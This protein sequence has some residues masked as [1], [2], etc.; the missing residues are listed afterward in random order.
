MALGPPETQATFEIADVHVSPKTLHPTK[1]TS[2][3][4]G[5][6]ELEMATMT[7]LIATAWGIE[8]HKVLG[9]PDW[10][11]MERFDVIARAPSG[12]TQQALRPMLQ[13]LLEKRFGLA[14]HMD[15]RP[16]VAAYVLSVGSGKPK[17]KESDSAAPGCQR[18]AQPPE[19]GP[20]PAVC[21]GLTMAAFAAQLGGAA[22]DYLN[23]PVVDN[24]KLEGAWDF[25]LKWTPRGRLAAAGAE[26]ITIFDAIDKQLGLKLE[27]K[28]IPAP[29][30]VVD[31]VNRKPTDNP[32][33]VAASLPPAPPPHFEVA[34]LRPTDPQL[35]APVFQ[36]PPNGQ[37]TIRGVTLSYLVQ[38]VWFVTP[39]MIADAPKWMDTDR[40]DIVAKVSSTPG[41]AP[42]TDMD[43]MIVMVRQLLED[44]FRLKTHMEERAVRAYTLT[45]IK[46]KLQRADPANRTGCK[47][48][49]GA[50]RKDPRLTNPARA[51]L[52]TCRNM[53]MAQFADR[54]PNIANAM[55]QLN[56][57]IRSPVA[58]STGLSGAWG[59]TLSFT[60]GT[61][62]QPAASAPA[63]SAEPAEPNGA[64]SLEEA[65]SSQLGL[66]LELMKRPAQLLVIDHVEQQPTEN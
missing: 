39:E 21:H 64:L 14:V 2:F 46:P 58:D 19:A 6:F 40:W 7:D 55:N 66:K 12:T 57:N 48:G 13:S 24:T 42:R 63:V 4:D 10:L 20:I 18:Q 9:G 43:S 61:G 36:T 15:Q 16:F 56:T 44:R 35:Q 34:T 37:I 49:P 54:L 45:A 62:A 29:V 1:R 23:A 32:P 33:G 8:P 27:A 50:D 51:R 31:R 38:T 28:Q 30:L 17:L 65:I 22:G 11:D 47:E 60:N 53:T 5:R 3:R 25:T 59:F 52:V 26:G 41:S